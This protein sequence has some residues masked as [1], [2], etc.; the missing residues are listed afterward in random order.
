MQMYK[1]KYNTKVKPPLGVMDCLE[2]EGLTWRSRRQKSQTFRLFLSNLYFSLS[3]KFVSLFLKNPSRL[4]SPK[5]E[6]TPAFIESG[7]EQNVP[8][9]SQ[10]SKVSKIETLDAYIS[11]FNVRCKETSI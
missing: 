10:L 9:E 11:A 5:V 3:P 2:R 6:G 1:V 8:K 4:S 7:E